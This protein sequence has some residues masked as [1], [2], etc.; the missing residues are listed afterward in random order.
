[1]LAP[2]LSL[3]RLLL[4]A[5]TAANQNSLFFLLL[6]LQLGFAHVAVAPGLLLP[7]VCKSACT[8]TH[9]NPLSP[10]S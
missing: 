8:T 4:L 3:L 2:S 9:T 5:C 6:L 7:D 1:M 10:G